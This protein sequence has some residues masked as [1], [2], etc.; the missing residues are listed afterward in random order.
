VKPEDLYLLAV[1]GRERA[2]DDE[3]PGR[4][5]RQIEP[6][7]RSWAGARLE[8]VMLSGS[9]AKSTALRGSDVDLFLSLAPDGVGSMAEV[10]AGLAAHFCDY[11]PRARNVS[12][13]IQFEG[14]S[15]DLVPGRRRAGST[16]HTLWQMRHGTWLQTDVGEQIRHVRSSGLL[17]EILALKIWRKRNGLRFPSFLLELAV[18]RAIEPRR[19]VSQSFLKVLEFLAT[20]FASA[21]LTD[22]AN[23]NNVVSESLTAEEKFRIAAAAKMSL[24]AS[25]WSEVL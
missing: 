6:L 9:Y 2:G 5:R 3:A 11:L 25:S 23:S 4:V 17:D 15:V 20:D 13:R 12:V 24:G 1:I 21:R 16:V 8:R 19:S 22:P 10:H 7:V 18:L 14:A